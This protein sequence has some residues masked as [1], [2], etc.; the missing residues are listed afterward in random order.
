A[1]STADDVKGLLKAAVRDDNCVVFIEHQN[2]YTEK[3][4][5]PEEEYT[6]P[7]GQGIVRR[8]GTDIT[9]VAYSYMAPVALQAAEMVAGDGI[10]VEMIDPRT[11]RPLDVDLIAGSVSKTGR[12]LV[13][14]QAPK[15]GCFGETIV[16]TTQERCFSDMKAPARIVA[17][18]DVPPP[19]AAP[20]ERENLPTPEK[21]AQAI[22]ELCGR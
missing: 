13:V 22:R 17:A 10:S 16:Y 15:F 4:V 14:C 20:L 2:L 19:M 18:Y 5:C 7:L 8:E 9:V 12:L 6:I 21:V 11:L 3:G 1:P